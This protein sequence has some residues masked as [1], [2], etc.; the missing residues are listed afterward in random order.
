MN[1]KKTGSTMLTFTIAAALAT[2]CSNSEKTG[3]ES[4][5][6][7]SEGDSKPVE[8]VIHSDSGDSVESFD[9]RFGNAIRSKFPNYTITY[10][11]TGKGTSKSELFAAN[12][13]IDMNFD[14]IGYF[15][16]SMVKNDLQ[17]DMSE[18]IKKENIDLNQLDPVAVNGMKQLSGGGLWGIPVTN[19]NVV[20][21]YNKDLFDKFGVPYP[22]DGLTWDE[23]A[24]LSKQLTRN[25]NGQQIVGLYGETGHVLRTNQYSLGT[26][27]PKTLK[28]TFS[29]NELWNKLL[30][31]IYVK[32]A[33]NAGYKEFMMNVRSGNLP[34]KDNFVKDRNLAMYVGLTST[35][36]TSASAMEG[37][38]WDI[39]TLPVFK[40]M[41]GTG[42]QP[43]PVYF[44]VTKTSK[45]KEAAI[46]VIKYLVSEEFQLAISKKGEVPVLTSDT[47]KKAFAQGSPFKD[48]NWS[49]VF[50]H[51][52]AAIPLKSPYDGTPENEVKALLPKVVLGETDMNTALRTIDENSNKKIEAEQAK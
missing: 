3:Q 33:S 45:N 23:A 12:Q 6:S 38:N 13:P 28:A 37:M 8:L 31:A 51:K 17:Y 48:K 10:I 32:P 20:L 41:P 49:A 9:E 52:P 47:V 11:K 4:N 15:M 21:F 39:A 5:V 25:E 14:S 24:E 16:N 40:D 22:K 34:T 27:D 18:L 2:G 1:R 46:K 29:T 43:Y 42:S 26:V 30:E 35:V 7:L 44:S 50:A 19:L 36:F